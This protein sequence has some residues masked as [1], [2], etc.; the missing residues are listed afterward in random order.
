VERWLLSY[1]VRKHFGKS[2]DPVMAR[3]LFK[4]YPIRRESFNAP[5]LAGFRSRRIVT[6]W[7]F[8]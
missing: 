5:L 8:S 2:A 1:T 4:L 6:D 3:A 7:P